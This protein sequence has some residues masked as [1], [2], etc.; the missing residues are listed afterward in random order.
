MTMT[1]RMRAALKEISEY[2]LDCGCAP[3]MGQCYDK[4][5]LREAVVELTEIAE[6][7]LREVPAPNVEP[8]PDDIFSRIT[9]DMARSA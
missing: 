7:A 5:S 9:R 4:Q 8:E 3:C 2:R 6:R 1:E